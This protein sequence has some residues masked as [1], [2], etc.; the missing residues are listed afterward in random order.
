MDNYAVHTDAGLTHGEEFADQGSLN[1]FIKVDILEH[2]KAALP[3][4]SMLIRFLVSSASFA[5]VFRTLVDRVK[6]NFLTLGWAASTKEALR[7]LVGTI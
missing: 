6:L 5:S 4:S 1:R 7:S 3:P 2:I